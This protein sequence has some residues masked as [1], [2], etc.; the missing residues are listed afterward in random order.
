MADRQDAAPRISALITPSAHLLAHWLTVGSGQPLRLTFLEPSPRS[1]RGPRPSGLAPPDPRHAAVA[2]HAAAQRAGRLDL[3]GRGAPHL[4]DRRPVARELVPGRAPAPAPWPTPRPAP[5]IRASTPI[6]LTFSKPV[7][8]VLGGK[9]PPVSPITQGT[10]HPVNSHTIVFRPRATATA[11]RRTCSWGSRAACTSSAARPTVDRAGRLDAAPAAAAGPARLPAAALPRFGARTRRPRRRPP[12]CTPP[13]GSFD[14][15][16]H[17][18][19]ARAAQHVGARHVRRDDQ[20][21]DHGVP[22]RP[23]DH[24]RR[25]RRARP[26]GRR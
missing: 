12:P 5:T 14:W 9:M 11:W 2:G 23:R 10:W 24:P 16:W 8:Q 22:E 7:E 3:R 4:G 20:G 6:S 18:T 17:N 13:S 15:R 26:P 25:R 19:P 1:P 21:R